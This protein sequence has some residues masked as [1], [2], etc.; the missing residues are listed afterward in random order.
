MTQKEAIK[1]AT[2]AGWKPIDKIG[3]KLQ[4][5]V[6]IWDKE[7]EGNPLWEAMRKAYPPMWPKCYFAADRPDD[8][9]FWSLICVKPVRKKS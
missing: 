7:F 1:L 3:L 5:H 8:S 2:D 9:V 4:G 6:R